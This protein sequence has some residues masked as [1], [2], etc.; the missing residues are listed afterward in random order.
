MEPSFL[1]PPAA[2]FEF[3]AQWLNAA[4]EAEMHEPNAMTLA[5][6]GADGRPSARQVLLKDYSAAGFEFYTSYASRKGL[7]MAANPQVSAVMFWDRLYRQV[8][9]EGR[10][11]K[12]SAE[13]SE[14][15]FAARPRG[16][17]ISA[18]ASAQSAPIDSYGVLQARVAE[19]EREF[20]GK[21]VPRPPHWGGYRIR[22][23]RIEFWQGRRNRLHERLCYCLAD[24][25]WD[26]RYLAP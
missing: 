7:E 17:Q 23:D 16:S 6:V 20:A 26:W 3:F 24:E 4:C 12:L 13:V 10:V 1:Y 5:T 11:E 25:Q 21:P 18:A 19:L 8:R 14:R 22:A 2:P 15:Y 9:I